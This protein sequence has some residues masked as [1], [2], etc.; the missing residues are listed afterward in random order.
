[1]IQTVTGFLFKHPLTLSVD[2][3]LYST[4]VF[5][6]R[7]LQ[8]YDKATNKQPYAFIILLFRLSDMTAPKLKQSKLLD[9]THT[10]IYMTVKFAKI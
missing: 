6:P 8:K 5:T 10:H 4:L 3:K 2:V 9:H 7:Q 1:M